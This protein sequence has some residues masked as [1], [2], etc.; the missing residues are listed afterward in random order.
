MKNIPEKIKGKCSLAKDFFTNVFFAT[1][2]STINRVRETDEFTLA[3]YHGG[4]KTSRSLY[5]LISIICF[6]SIFLLWASVFCI[7]E[8]SKGDGRVIPSSKEKIIQSLDGGILDKINVIEGQIV[9]AGDIIANLDTIRTEAAVKESESKYRALLAS[10][11]RLLAE[12]SGRPLV[13]PDELSSFPEITDREMILYTSRKNN[14]VSSINDIKAS[15]ELLNR[16]LAINTRLMA[17]GASSKVDVIRLRKQLVDLNMKESELNFN[18]HVKSGEELSKISAEVDSLS[19]KIIGQR[20]LL[21]KSTITSPVR[22]IVK[23]IEVNTIGGVIPPNGTIM[24]IVPLDDRLLIEAKI[25]PRDIAFIHPGQ[26]AIVK[27]TAYDYSIYGGLDGEV[28][29][30]SPDTISDPQKP[31]AVFYRVYIRTTKDH[32]QTVDKKQH[33]ISPGMVASVDIKTGK[34][35]ILQYL[36]KPFNKVGEALRER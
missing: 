32:L 35:T 3:D 11:V 23:N 17:Q 15:K 28:V 34:K 20:D 18:Y 30:I 4:V 16:E 25:L 31:D 10:K 13:F 29:T 12:I 7:D 8:V 22:G 14:Y 21:K 36:I 2:K 9:Q 27:I 6:L 24:N 33:F 19:Q 26:R 1:D 5:I